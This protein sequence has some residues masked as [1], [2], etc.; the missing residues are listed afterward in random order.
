MKYWRGY[1][2]AGI[3]AAISWALTELG[4]KF[5]ALV[6]MVYPYVTRT[7][8]NMLTQWSSTVDT[9]LWQLVVVLL[10]IVALSTIVLMVVLKWNPIQWFGWVLACVSML[11][12]FHTVIYGLNNHAGPL[13]EDVRMENIGYTETDLVNAT[14][15]Y[16]DKANELA[17][18]MERDA[19]SDPVFPSFEELAQQAAN[20]FEHLT[21]DR[22]YSVF[23]G[24][25]TPVKK[26]GWSNYYSSVGIT[27]MFVSLTGEAAVNPDIPVVGLPFNMCHEMAHRMCIAN[28]RDANFGGFLASRFNESKE[29]QYS[30]YFMAFRYCYNTLITRGTSSANAAA[31]QALDGMNAQLRHDLQVWDTF[32]ASRKNEKATEISD[33]AMDTT[34]KISGNERGIDSYDDVGDLLVCWYVQEIV[35]PSQ[36]EEE[37]P[38]DP[39]DESQV[40]LSGLVNAKPTEGEPTP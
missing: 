12:M 22:S 30:A 4:G 32:F 27:G 39:F 24:D 10:G 11:F 7:M 31:K 17:L 36:A 21:Y 20:G 2:A 35:L 37:S 34:L 26:L 18:Q 13:A 1:I 9:C 38:F 3:F 8:Q 6:D 5:S 23:A 28:E 16:R 14:L 40:D 19:N 15:Y 33:N 25:L 29:F